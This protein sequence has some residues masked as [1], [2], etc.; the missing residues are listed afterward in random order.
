VLSSFGWVPED[1]THL[2]ATR[3]GFFFTC[4]FAKLVSVANFADP[5]K[6][7]RLSFAKVSCEMEG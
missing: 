2:G 6:I 7:R 1:L 4:E 5:N 3:V